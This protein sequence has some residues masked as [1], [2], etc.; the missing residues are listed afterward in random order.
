MKTLFITLIA[1]CI[2]VSVFSQEGFQRNEVRFTFQFVGSHLYPTLSYERFMSQQLSLGG[3]LGIL[4][5][6]SDF[7]HHRCH[8]Y[9]HCQ[10]HRYTFHGL[11]LSPNFRWYFDSSRN[12]SGL[13]AEISGNF[14]AYSDSFIYG[15]EPDD[16]I[17]RRLRDFSFS[18][19]DVG[20]GLTVGWKFQF[21]DDFAAEVSL[22]GG[23]NFFSNSNVRFNTHVRTGLAIGV[24][25]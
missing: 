16:D 23:H 21:D 22:G 20:V 25:F 15:T 10:Q 3:S 13:F 18:Y 19:T 1:L 8:C 4:T 7:R 6:W 11:F 2:S 9:Y 17:K 12:G 14:F 24:R 5:R